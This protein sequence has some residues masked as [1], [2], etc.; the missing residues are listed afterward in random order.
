M[1]NPILD[2]GLWTG[3]ELLLPRQAGSTPRQLTP[4]GLDRHPLRAPQ[5]H[6]WETA[7]ERTGLRFGHDLLAKTGRSGTSKNVGSEFITNSSV[8]YCQVGH[9]D[10]SLTCPDSGSGAGKAI[11]PNLPIGAKWVPK[12]HA[13]VDRQG[14]P[15][16]VK[17]TNAYCQNCT[18]FALILKT[19]GAYQR[20]IP[21]SPRCRPKNFYA[22]K[23][24]DHRLCRATAGR[25]ALKAPPEIESSGAAKP[26]PLGSQAHPWT[27]E[28]IPS[29]R[30]PLR[31]PCRRL[32][33]VT[34]ARLH[35]LLLELHSPKGALLGAVKQGAAVNAVD[36][37]PVCS[38]R[39]IA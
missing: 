37:G 18:D 29:P 6:P 13:V 31:A 3:L 1:A 5:R 26:V 39:M 28:K 11:G 23:P 7:P 25:A 35:P 30:H 17:A 38:G 14:I 16:A 19:P 32:R 24:D 21:L 34:A 20:P 12:C 8:G 36:H 33:S 2:E 9:L 4:A 15:L 10:G 27:V 22:G